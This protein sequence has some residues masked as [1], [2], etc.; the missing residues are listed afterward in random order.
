MSDPSD[1]LCL[2]RIDKLARTAAAL[3][4]ALLAAAVS[5]AGDAPPQIVP[6]SP[7][8]ATDAL[9][10]NVPLAGEVGPPRPGRFAGIFYFLWHEHASARDP[11]GEGPYDVSRILAR[12]P[13]A[14]KKPGSPLWGPI[15][16]YH[17]WGKPLFGYYSSADPWVIRRHAMLL[18]EAGIDALIFDATNALTYRPVYRKLL[19]VFEDVRRAGGR[20]PQVAFM[21]NTQAGPTAEK[22]YRD[23]YASGLHRDLW[24]KWQGKPLLLCDPA[25]ASAELKSA[26]TLRRAHWPFE[27]VNTPY[28]WHWE[29]T[30]PQPYGYADD[31]AKPEQVNV[32][33]AQNLRAK[34]GKVTNMS[35][36]DAR[37]RSF[38]D[39]RRDL[40]PGATDRGLNFEEQWKRALELEPPFVMVTG[41]NEW[42]A[43]RWG[44]PGG[45]IVFVDQFD[46]EHSRDIEPMDGGHGDNYY[47]QLAAGVRR[48]KGAP[49][50]PPASAPIAIRIDG[51]FDQWKDV[52]PEYLD[53]AGETIPRDA[54]G[55]AGLR[56]ADRSGRNDL[57][58]FKVARDERNVYF[59][60]RTREPLTARTDPGWMWLLI[61]ADRDPATGWEGFEFIANR[62]ADAHGTAW[63]EKSAGGWRWKRIVPVALRAAG[64]DLQIEI[65]RTALGLP[66][67]D[68]ELSIDFKWADDLRRPGDILDFYTSGDVAP[69]GRFKFRYSTK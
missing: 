43:G 19:E 40:S 3:A 60:A 48:Y 59:L 44:Q 10:R 16:A 32:S 53:G 67:G 45:P 55:S 26:F 27:M 52:G 31:P 41:W 5:S 8:P 2:M 36:G 64:S 62:I 35:A 6:A 69:E 14:L 20:T 21:V 65:P 24:F 56:Y 50:I 33:V 23:L 22:I 49:P 42:I 68:R 4:L 1:I 7:W 15:G 58:S 66:A 30:Y 46:R 25:Q 9:G 34:D 11:L 47:L 12:D 17:Y 63:L 61:D 13:D 18:A 38:H 57:A 28:A 51:G 29:A 39:G 54:P 37:G